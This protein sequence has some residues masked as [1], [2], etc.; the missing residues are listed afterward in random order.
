MFGEVEQDQHEEEESLFS[1]RIENS[2][3]ISDI[4]SCLCMN[5]KTHLCHIEAT[6]DSLTFVLTG[7]IYIYVYICI[8]TYMYICICKYTNAYIHKCISIY[9]QVY[10]YIHLHTCTLYQAKQNLRKHG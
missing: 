2:K 8:Y 9:V 3:T 10:T 6:P 5:R 7:N 1:C 4:L